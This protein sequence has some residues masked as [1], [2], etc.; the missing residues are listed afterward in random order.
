MQQEGELGVTEAANRIGVAP[1]TAHR[2]LTT[3]GSRTR[4]GASTC[5]FMPRVHIRGWGWRWG[6]L[7]VVDV[8]RGPVGPSAR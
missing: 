5:E 8:A 3:L 4:P 2:L 6:G 1:S 7:V